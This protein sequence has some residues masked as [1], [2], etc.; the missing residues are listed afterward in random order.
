[1][2]KQATASD[3]RE[4]IQSGLASALM[5]CHNNSVLSKFCLGERER[6]REEGPMLYTCVLPL[7]LSSMAVDV[8]TFTCLLLLVS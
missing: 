6:E 2:F 1:M 4:H 7:V 3:Y 5:P 8:V